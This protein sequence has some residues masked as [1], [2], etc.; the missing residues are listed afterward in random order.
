MFT[1]SN[2]LSILRS[3][4]Q[5]K[6]Q[7]CLFNISKGTLAASLPHSLLT[8]VC[9]RVFLLAYPT[10]QTSPAPEWLLLASLFSCI[11]QPFL[12]TCPLGSLGFSLGVL[13]SRFLSWP[14]LPPLFLS[15]SPASLPSHGLVQS[16]APPP[17]SVWALPCAYDRS[18]P[19]IYN[20][21]FSST[22]LGAVMSSCSLTYEFP[23]KILSAPTPNTLSLCWRWTDEVN[24]TSQ[25]YPG[26]DLGH[27]DRI[28][29]L[30]FVP[31]NS[32]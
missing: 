24:L 9:H 18:L 17:C 15:G 7:T 11:T 6:W 23:K 16:A 20:K 19:H 28:Y 13:G 1:S 4:T 2:F 27:P 30:I 31:W 26:V 8:S 5:D 21:T 32:A 3:Q 10:P 25:S 12:A 14:P 22:I 29:F